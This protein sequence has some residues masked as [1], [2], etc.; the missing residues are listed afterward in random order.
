MTV[1]EVPRT[2]LS[3]GSRVKRMCF[4]GKLYFGAACCT[5]DAWK[6]SKTADYP[7]WDMKRYI[8]YILLVTEKESKTLGWFSHADKKS[9]HDIS[10][11][12]HS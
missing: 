9:G 3:L 12:C 10:S 1:Q 4:T 8:L 6:H 7:S 5:L 11:S 2:D